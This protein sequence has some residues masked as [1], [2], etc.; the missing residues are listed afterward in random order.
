MRGKRTVL[1][2]T[3]VF[4]LGCSGMTGMRNLSDKVEHD[5][6]VGNI[7]GSLHPEWSEADR[8]T[9]CHMTWSWKY[10]YYRG[11]D[12]HGYI[13]DYSKFSPYGYKDPYGLDVPF[14]TFADYYYSNWWDGPWLELPQNIDPPM[15]FTCYDKVNDGN[16]QPNDF[17]GSVIVV[18]QSGKGD[19]RSIQEGVDKARYG[20]TVFVRSGTY[21][22]SVKLKEG[23]RLWGENPH[24]TIINP[25]FTD[26]AI[27]AANNCDISGFTF[28]GTGMNYKTYEF[29]SGVH[30]VDCDSTLVIRGNIFDSNA[31]FG[32]L[33]ESSRINGTPKNN[34]K[35]YIEFKEALKNLEYGGYP[36][37]RVIGNTFYVIGE[38]A[39]YSI[40]AAPE[41][42]NNIFIGN[43]KTLGM[44]Q[45]SRPY[46][47]NN[48]FYRN[49][50]TI[51]MNR[52]MPVIAYNIMLENYWGQRVIEGAR[53]IIHDN[54][55]W[56]SPYYKEFSEDGTPILYRPLP[57]NGEK[58][59]NPK[60][61]DPD[62]GN[63]YLS[64]DSPLLSFTTGTKRYGLV[65]EPGIQQ[66]PVV[67][68]KRSF[69][70][71]FD[72][73]N[74]ASDSIIEAIKKQK[75][76]IKKLSVSY[77]FE[78]KSFMRVKYDK[79][80]DQASVV[81]TPDPVSGI[82][83]DVPVWIMQDGKRHKTYASTLFSTSKTLTDSGTVEFDGK[84]IIVENGRFK[85]YASTYRDEYNIGEKIFRENTGGLYL[86]YDQYLNG[87]IGPM[88]TFF[89]GYLT[90]FGGAVSDKKVL[91]DGHDCVVITYPN[92]GSDQIYKFYLD[93]ENNY[94]PLRLEHFFE[95]ELY[96]RIDGYKYEKIDGI[97]FPV[98][99]T[100]T[101]FAVK[102]PYIGKVVGISTMKIKPGTIRLNEQ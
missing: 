22:E 92:I 53:P 67:P 9:K 77:S 79:Y 94:R 102:K 31:V 61:I 69:A 88:G 100:I 70:A 40:H 30:A 55:T 63:F 14:N 5:L 38:R 85:Q 1:F 7:S 91:V 42:A 2:V 72:N 97:N 58:E 76:Q 50:V 4:A 16:A 46:I 65:T 49:N 18:D 36:N 51:N 68:C 10:G 19:A 66:P 48:V 29:N 80:G 41:I 20:S 27:I 98:S 33:V 71:E 99:V 89:F 44:T 86:D 37:P 93:P 87:S 28:T 13:S 73:R 12:R 45:H 34:E 43:V 60:F 82:R 57:G 3:F 56:N 78:Y 24:T 84:K 26:S 17:T 96:R 32:V 21:V 74:K 39:V 23:I 6:R 101:D 59:T 90:A 81:I 75:L 52:S 64:T 62:G 95:R 15:H 83:Y 47:H 25:D 8:C 35:G 11:W 54:I